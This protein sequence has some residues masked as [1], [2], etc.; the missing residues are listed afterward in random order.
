LET[1][2]LENTIRLLKTLTKK[3]EI[4]LLQLKSNEST[5]ML[6]FFLEAQSQIFMESLSTL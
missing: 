3:A 2:A 6:K 1:K 5:K 4:E